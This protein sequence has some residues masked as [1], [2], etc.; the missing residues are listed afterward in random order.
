MAERFGDKLKHIRLQQQLTLRQVCKDAKLDETLF[1]QLESNQ[2][3][4]TKMVIEKLAAY[5]ALNVS[6]DTLKA[7]R[8]ADKVANNVKNGD[9]DWFDNSHFH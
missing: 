4:P 7:W 1:I 9:S 3:C 8:D 6:Y 2:I 5:T